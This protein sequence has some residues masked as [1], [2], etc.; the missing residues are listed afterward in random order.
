MSRSQA[1]AAFSR[2]RSAFSLQLVECT[3]PPSSACGPVAFTCLA[4]RSACAASSKSGSLMRLTCSSR[5]RPAHSS[6]SSAS[7]GQAS[8]TA[9]GSHQSTCVRTCVV[10][11][12]HA[13]CRPRAARLRTSAGLQCTRSASIASMAPSRPGCTSFMRGSVK[14]L[15]RCVCAS[16][17]PGNTRVPARSQLWG[18]GAASSAG[19]TDCTRPASSAMRANTGTPS[20]CGQSVGSSQRGSRALSRNTGAFMRSAPWPAPRAP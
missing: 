11:H 16:T 15:S 17:K 3:K 4:R 9:S 12:S 20:R 19:R 1:C 5:T 6:A 14:A 18:A 13:H 8:G 10:P 2:L 7:T